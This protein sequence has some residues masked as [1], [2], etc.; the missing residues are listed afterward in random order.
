VLS[1][2]VEPQTWY[3]EPMLRFR[4]HGT[5]PDAVA[6]PHTFAWLVLAGVL[7][8]VLWLAPRRARWLGPYF[9]L[10]WWL[11]M[12]FGWSQWL[13]QALTY[14]E[15]L[16]TKVRFLP[17]FGFV[18]LAISVI[19]VLQRA[20]PVLARRTGRLAPAVALI[21]AA[22]I[23]FLAQVAWPYFVRSTV[24]HTLVAVEV[25]VIGVM[26]FARA[27]AGHPERRLAIPSSG[28]CFAAT[29]LLTFPVSHLEATSFWALVTG[30]RAQ[31]ERE[32]QR[33]QSGRR[34]RPDR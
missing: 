17:V 5:S 30:E 32:L 15:I 24:A 6:P 20:M 14:S 23:G 26:L 25:L 19:V 34:Q 4:L 13:L 3:V 18:V 33:G 21:V 8:P 11:T 29:V 2:L 12:S 7:L 27:R 9:V 10:L 28:L 16:D 31:P 1:R 22:A